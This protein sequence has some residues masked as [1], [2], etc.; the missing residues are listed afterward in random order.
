MV[1]LVVIVLVA[2][3]GIGRLWLVQ[4]RHATSLQTVDGFRSS[5]ERLSGQ[6]ALPPQPGMGRA[7][8]PAPSDD[9][10]PHPYRDTLSPERRAAAKRR[11]EAR[12]RGAM[13]SSDLR[14]R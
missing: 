2:A 8:S 12:R 13:R 10:G 7:P 5:L 4:R 3:A 11:L 1:Y 9:Q 6:A 14:S